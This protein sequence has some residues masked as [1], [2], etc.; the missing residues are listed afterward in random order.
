M[1]LPPI[2]VHNTLSGQKEDFRPWNPPRVNMYVCGITPYSSSHFGH[3]MSAVAFDTI[4]R[5]LVHRGYDVRYVQ[6]FTDID[7]KI[8]QRARETGD[9][10]RELPEQFIAQYLESMR[11]LNVMSATVN[12]RATG[13]LD[14]IVELITG[15]I[16]KGH[17]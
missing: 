6:N 15:L 1:Q 10:P 4:R 11:K 3:G 7:D 8:I 2:K 9:D 16:A 5:Y 12:P 17:A 13:E 14:K